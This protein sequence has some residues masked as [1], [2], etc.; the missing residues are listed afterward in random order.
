MIQFSFLSLIISFLV[1]FAVSRVVYSFGPTNL[2]FAQILVLLIGTAIVS[3]IFTMRNFKYMGKEK[4]RSPA[5]HNS[6]IR[7][8][9]IN[10]IILFIISRVF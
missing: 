8:F 7:T 9:L 5:F 4:W 10:F 3:L 6:L 1:Y 2:L